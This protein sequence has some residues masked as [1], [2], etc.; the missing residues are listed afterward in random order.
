[1][2]VMGG[3]DKNDVLRKMLLQ[4]TPGS[5]V[6]SVTCDYVNIYQWGMHKDVFG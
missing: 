3:W 4:V 6:K 5:M 2:Y 1:M